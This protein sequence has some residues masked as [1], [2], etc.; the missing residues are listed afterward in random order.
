MSGAS[1]VLVVDDEET[2]RAMLRRVLEKGGFTVTAVGTVR[3]AL[4]LISQSRFDVLISDLNVGHP[5][6]GFVVVSAMRRTQPGTL[7]F[8]LTG[9]P[10]FE[11]ALEAMRQHVND[12][13]IEGTPIKELVEKIKT[14]LVQGQPRRHLHKTKRV[15]DVIEEN[16]DVVIAH[17]LQQ[18]MANDDLRRVELSDADRI[19]HV[20]GLL[21]EAITHARN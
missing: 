3:E 5:A 8:I 19:D 1:T 2:I 4:A 9:Y 18:V 7:T 11:T 16:K 21:D 6:D 10:A 13:L 14:G 20:P 15:P 17:W 12:Y